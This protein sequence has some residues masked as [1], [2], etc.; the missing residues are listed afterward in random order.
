[1]EFALGVVC[2]AWPVPQPV[3][4]QLLMAKIVPELETVADCVLVAS[5]PI[6]NMVQALMRFWHW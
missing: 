3:T 4:E 1:M 5:T 6:R 2:D